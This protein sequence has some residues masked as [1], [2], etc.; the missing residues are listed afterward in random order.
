MTDI[1]RRSLAPLTDEAWKEIDNQASRTL[2][3]NLSGRALV[4][5]SGPHGWTMAAVNLGSVASGEP[6]NGM[7]WGRRNAQNLIEIR[8]AFSLQVSDLDNVSRGCKTPNLETLI[9]A[10]QNIALLEEGAIYNSFDEAGITGIG[11]ASTHAPVLLQPKVSGAFTMA[12]EAGV[13]AIQKS[14]IEGP[15][16]L[17]LGTTPLGESAW[18]RQ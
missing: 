2:K 7:S 10:A 4:D 1:L 11:K 18:T 8:A 17:V 13:L 14:G 9:T 5:F 12:V 6:V 3:G 16:A 15:Y